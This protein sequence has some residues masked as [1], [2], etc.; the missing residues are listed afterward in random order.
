MRCYFGLSDRSRAT[1]PSCGGTVHAQAAELSGGEQQRVAIA[2]AVAN[3]LRIL[4]ADEPTGNLDPQA[5]GHAKPVGYRRAHGSPRDHP[6]G[7]VVAL[8]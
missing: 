4:L 2:R 6:G 7:A 8:G 5:S 3:A 1:L